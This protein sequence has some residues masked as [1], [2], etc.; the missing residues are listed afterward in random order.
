MNEITT[1]GLDLAKRVACRR[2]KVVR[3][4]HDATKPA[5][6][7]PPEKSGPGWTRTSDQGIMS[8]VL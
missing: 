7:E 1:V 4:T 3:R 6:N 8:P 5:R 2:A